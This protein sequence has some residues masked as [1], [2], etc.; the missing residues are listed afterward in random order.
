M[1]SP[2]TEASQDGHSAAG[3]SVLLLI[4]RAGCC[5]AGCATGIAVTLLVGF[6]VGAPTTTTGLVLFR[7]DEVEGQRATG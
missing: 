3:S 7:S 5:C 2:A 1:A 6:L 4:T